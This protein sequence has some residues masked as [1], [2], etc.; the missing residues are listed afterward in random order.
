MA[1][2]ITV[3]LN[4]AAIYDIVL[5]SSFS[6]L[7]SEVEKLDIKDRKLCIISDSNVAE[8]Y[9][10]Q[11]INELS[12]CC[13]Q[14]DSFVFPAGE[15]QKQLSTVNQLYETL[16]CKHY[17]RKDILVAL[18]GGVVGDLCGYAA[19]TYLRGIRFIQIPTTLLSQVDSSIGGKT[20]VDFHAYKNMVGAF[21]MPRLVYT[22]TSTL[23]T[24][25]E[26]Q[27]LSGMGEIIK[28]GLIKDASYYTWL[29][30]NHDTIM[31]RDLDT[32]E[33]M[34]VVS[35]HIK[36][37]VVEQDPTEQGERALLNLGHTLGHAIEKLLNFQMLHGECVA[38]GCLA[39][40]YL[41]ARRE[42]L[43]MTD[44]M[45]IRSTLKAF[46]LPVDIAELGLDFDQVIETTRSDKKMDSD[47][48]MFILLHSIGDAYIDRSVTATEMQE[49]LAWMQGGSHES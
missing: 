49:A 14:V 2:R 25:P 37:I 45:D 23:L 24:L 44:V 6:Q 48:I 28:H 39:A 4:G 9:L 46:H 43:P 18:G 5:E 19:A 12:P 38:L 30:Q 36:R 32:C 21:H 20:G 29:K 1:D 33:K 42:V 26:D 13:R 11:V 31:S 3:H 40:A 8:L 10:E 34:I 15:A 41:S 27:Y 7:S 17:D 47:I 35:N 16:I 22:N